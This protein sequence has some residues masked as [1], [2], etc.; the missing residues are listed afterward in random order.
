[1]MLCC[2]MC[3]VTALGFQRDGR[4]MYSSSEDG[5]LKIWDIRAPAAQRDYES[6]GGMEATYT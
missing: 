3:S 5:T 2:Y 4:W 6:R 1:M